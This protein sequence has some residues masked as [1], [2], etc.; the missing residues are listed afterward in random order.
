MRPLPNKILAVALFAAGVTIF[1]RWVP[2]DA[3]ISFRYALN[4]AE[5]HGLVFNPGD[6]VE[7]YSN[8]LWTLILGLGRKAGVD[9]VVAAVVLSLVCAFGTILLALHLFDGI[10]GDVAGRRT[11]RSHLMAVSLTLVVSLPMVY[12]ASSG[13][14]TFAAA[15]FLLLGAVLHLKAEREGRQ[16]IHAWSVI[17]YLLVAVLRPEG[18][19]YA[20]INA[21]ILYV[22][23]GRRMPRSVVASLVVSLVVFSVF[24]ASRSLYYGSLVPN[25]YWAKPST[26]IGFAK[27]L[28]GG[29]KYLARYFMVSGLVLMLPVCVLA[30]RVPS[31]RYTVRYLAGV[32]LVQLGFI[33]WVGGDVLRFDRFGVAFHAVLLAVALAGA[34]SWEASRGKRPLLRAVVWGAVVIALTLNGLRI[35]RAASKYCIHDW[36]HA[37]FHARL[38]KALAEALPADATLVFNEMGAT[39]YYS[40]LVTYDMIGLTDKTVG[41]IIFESYRRYGTTETPLCQRGIADYLLAN[42]PTCIILPSYRPIDLTG[43]SSSPRA[44]HPIWY[45][46]YS[47]PVFREEYRADFSVEHNPG[48]RL[49]VFVRRG[50]EIDHSALDLIHGPP[51]LKVTVHE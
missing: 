28:M 19:G 48:K 45:G 8:F 42:H 24:L 22:R 37:H 16:E 50:T 32:L 36:M 39:P 26:T 13:L 33:I 7:G 47:H 27:P 51:C 12:W 10:A 43:F 23:L 9:I 17:A 5:G 46:I 1:L 30:F 4:F 20:A 35:H 29:V 34:V 44:F 6:R 38:G 14:E 41:S 21:V 15:F 18:I 2:D 31:V 40:R 11:Y 25:T 49:H 3:Y